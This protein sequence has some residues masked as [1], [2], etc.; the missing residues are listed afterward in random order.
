MPA[1][2]T[3]TK[4]AKMTFEEALA[5]LEEIIRQLEGGNTN[6]NDAITAYERGTALKR[7]CDDK[8]RDAQEKISRIKL[9]ETGNLT[10]ITSES[11]KEK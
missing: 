9:D 3:V 5:E 4:I 8:L 10:S 7:H 11:L 1:K 2:D 6:L